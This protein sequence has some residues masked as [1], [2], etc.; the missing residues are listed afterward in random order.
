MLLCMLLLSC[1]FVFYVQE[2]DHLKVSLYNGN[3]TVIKR[4]LDSFLDAFAVLSYIWKSDHANN[5][6]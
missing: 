6:G 5:M 2:H 3:Y 4:Q 1:V